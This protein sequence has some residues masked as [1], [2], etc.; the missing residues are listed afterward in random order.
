MKQILI[1]FLIASTSYATANPGSLRDTTKVV[2][3]DV[4]YEVT[5]DGSY[6][7]LNVSTVDKYMALSILRRGLIVYFDVKGKKKEN[8]YLKYPLQVVRPH[9][10]NA[11]EREQAMEN[12]NVGDLIDKLPSE[13]EY[14][15]FENTREFN[16]DL[17]DM[18][19][20]VLYT[21]TSE[22][23]LLTYSL[24]IPKYKIDPNPEAD[25][26]KLSIGVVTG[27]E[28]PPAAKKSG[29]TRPSGNGMKGGGRRGN[30]NGIAGDRGSV[31]KAR[32]SSRKNTRPVL[33]TIEHWFDANLTN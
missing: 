27:K 5:H 33:A 23:E 9:F 31:D 17:N 12:L 6:V 22:N 1:I 28:D 14:G 11:E 26:G 3:E 13:V 29:R 7:Y 10:K 16:K 2:K 32:A 15:F 30:S 18:D 25:F 4:T 8:V 19:I 20:T 24:K 21:Y